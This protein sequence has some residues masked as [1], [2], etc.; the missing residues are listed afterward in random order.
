MN[1]R[2]GYP[3][4]IVLTFVAVQVATRLTFMVVSRSGGNH[5]D[6]LWVY[7]GLDFLMVIFVPFLLVLEQRD[8]KNIIHVFYGYLAY[9]VIHTIS[10]VLQMVEFEAIPF[11]VFYVAGLLALAY[12]GYIGIKEEKLNKSGVR[13][14]RAIFI[15]GF[16]SALYLFLVQDNIRA[17]LLTYQ[18]FGLNTF[19]LLIIIV[20][21]L[22][23]DE[24]LL[25]KQK[26]LDDN[27]IRLG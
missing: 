10:I 20:Q 7:I 6:L 25:E 15:A 27:R 22:I 4:F 17:L 3:I 12:V 13:I 21:G 8:N 24:V 1:K 11:N 14:G 18:N 23:M 26:I 2:I 19:V 9:S 5:E 16:L